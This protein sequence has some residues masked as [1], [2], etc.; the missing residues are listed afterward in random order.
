MFNRAHL[1]RHYNHV[2][3]FLGRA[4]HQGKDMLGHI[5]NGIRNAKELYS[6]AE[7]VLQHYAPE[8]TSKLNGHLLNNYKKYD[9]IRDKVIDSHDQLEHGM[10]QIAGKLKLKVNIGLEYKQKNKQFR[11]LEHKNI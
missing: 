10:H 9:S 3:N 4:Y 2:K 7:P 1:T 11:L 8:H 5:D 6:I